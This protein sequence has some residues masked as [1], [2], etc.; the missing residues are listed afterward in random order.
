MLYVFDNWI[1][2]FDLLH[3]KRVMGSVHVEL[4]FDSCMPLSG[5]S[6]GE[7][8][9]FLYNFELKGFSKYQTFFHF[10]Q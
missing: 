10:F 6:F 8:K 9:C 7:F 1:L 5:V 3:L 4:Y 2:V